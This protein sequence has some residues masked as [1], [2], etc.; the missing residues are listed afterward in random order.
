MRISSA[1]F[2]KSAKQANDFPK[3][4][5]PEIAFCGRS[6]SGK[7]SLLNALTNSQGLARTSSSPGRTQLINFF[8]VDGQTY[9]VDLP[10]YGY[11]KVPK[12]IRDT[13]GEMI[14]SYLRNREPL[15]LAIMLV[16][17]RIPPTDSDQMMKD[18]LDH[19]G[20]PNLVVLTKTDKI[21]RNELTKALRT[22]AQTLQTKEIIAFS[23]ITGFGK[24]AVLK[25]IR[26]AIDHKPTQ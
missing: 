12:G 5:K 17:S 24:D 19:F 2:V 26:D 20:I 25:K 6:N 16:D 14:E 1:R 3:D 10:G 13:W 8:L 9:Y 11:A 23:A 15:K 4:K 7:S 18:W 21:S 22:C